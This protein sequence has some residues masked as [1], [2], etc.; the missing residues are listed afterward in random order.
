MRIVLTVVATAVIVLAVLFGLRWFDLVSQDAA[1]VGF[2][3]GIVVALVMA[4]ANRQK[5]STG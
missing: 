1:N 3:T 5:S 2:V 4:L